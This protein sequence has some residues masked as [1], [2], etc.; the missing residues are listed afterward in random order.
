MTN[1]RIHIRPLSVHC[2]DGLRLDGTEVT[3]PAPAVTVI[4][5]HGLL[6]DKT[7]WEPLIESLMPLTGQ[8]ASHIAF[9]ARGHGRS[10]RPHRRSD[11]D[12]GRLADDLACVIDHVP[13]QIVLVAHS[14]GCFTVLEYVG[15]HRRQASRVVDIVLFGASGEEPWWPALRTFRP[16][17][18]ALRWMRRRGPLDA[19]NAAGHR[20]L[21]ARLRSLAAHAKPGRAQLI[22][23]TEPVDPRVTADICTA[24]TKFRLATPMVDGLNE[25]RVQLITAEYDRVVPAAQTQYLATRISGAVLYHL[26]DAGHSM[27]LSDPD[28]AAA[29]IVSSIARYKPLNARSHALRPAVEVAADIGSDATSGG[30]QR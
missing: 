27:P 14:I 30:G 26:E 23:S 19:V 22:P 9:D 5:I 15:R 2:E 29:A 1:T 24:V 18:A 10:E 11:A 20:V 17:S 13:G 28:R 16:A 7:F 6:A 4:Y 25:I 12:F 8:W 3:S 21:A